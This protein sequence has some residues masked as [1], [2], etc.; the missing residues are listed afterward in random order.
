MTV[1]DGG[2]QAYTCAHCGAISAL[3]RVSL[4]AQDEDDGMHG[5]DWYSSRCAACAGES[6]WQQDEFFYRMRWP[7]G[8]IGPVAHGRTPDDVRALYDEARDIGARSPRAAA[9]L[10][11][12][13]LEMLTGIL[14]PGE[15]DINRAIA[16]LVRN[17]LPKQIQQAMD[18]LRVIG[19]EA[20]H[21][22]EIRLQDQPETVNGLFM[23]LNAVVDNQ[24]AQTA[25]IAEIYDSLPDDK[26]AWI[27][28]RDQRT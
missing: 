13:A 11:R 9:A 3:K 16:G 27:D 10:L 4:W 19:N 14:A 7:G 25:A 21:P 24:I 6:I 28:T 1:Y 12:L 23:L 5:T 8:Q 2:L 18:A 15:P 22:S 17:G 26:R 20:V